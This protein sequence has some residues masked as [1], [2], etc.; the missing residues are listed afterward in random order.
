MPSSA[1]SARVEGSGVPPERAAP[2]AVAERAFE[3]ERERLPRVTVELNEHIRRT[4]LSSSSSTESALKLTSTL[5]RCPSM[6]ARPTQIGG[7]S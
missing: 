1:A 7:Q 4:A 2:D 3:L 5:V 6:Y